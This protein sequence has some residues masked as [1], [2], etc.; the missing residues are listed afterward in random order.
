MHKRLGTW[1]YGVDGSYLHE[2]KRRWKVVSIILLAPSLTPPLLP[3]PRIV[4]SVTFTPMS[5]LYKNDGSGR[6]HGRVA[7][8][9]GSS[10][11]MGRAIALA[12]AQEGASVV[13]SD[14]RPEASAKGFEPDK[15]I[16]T[17]E[18]IIQ[19]GGRSVFQK[20]DMGKTDEVIAL[21]NFAV[22]VSLA[23]GWLTYIFYNFLRV[24]Y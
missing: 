22:E 20:C 17:H 23:I 7:I 2:N 14:L 21:V 4:N 13:C 16:P 18:V 10:S 5:T 9:T 11:G 12:L 15:H 8:V 19:N 6:L 1:C 3:F 24:G